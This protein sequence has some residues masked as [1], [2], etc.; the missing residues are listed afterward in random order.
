LELDL[1]KLS[2]KNY[3]WITAEFLEEKHSG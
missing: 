1:S 3:V 2:F